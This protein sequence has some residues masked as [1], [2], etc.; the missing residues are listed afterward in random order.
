MHCSD[1]PRVMKLVANPYNFVE[2]ILS[3]SKFAEESWRGADS[4][5]KGFQHEAT[6]AQYCLVH[7]IYI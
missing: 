3:T 1:H 2:E 7:N 4:G 5:D 6:R